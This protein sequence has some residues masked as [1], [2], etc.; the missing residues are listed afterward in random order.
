MLS[1]GVAAQA[2]IHEHA[3]KAAEAECEEVRAQVRGQERIVA[4]L[5]EEVCGECGVADSVMFCSV[6]MRR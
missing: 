2:K 1:Q 3:L 4:T 6:H 5:R